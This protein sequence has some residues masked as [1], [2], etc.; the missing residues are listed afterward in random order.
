VKGYFFLRE[1]TLGIVPSL[2]SP[3]KNAIEKESWLLIELAFAR[4]SALIRA[5]RWNIPT[6]HMKMASPQQVNK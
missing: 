1:K 3:S 2:Y 6:E 5:L 4:T